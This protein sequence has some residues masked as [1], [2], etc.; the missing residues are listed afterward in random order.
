MVRAG[1]LRHRVDIE[2]MTTDTDAW[3]Q[4]TNV[5]EAVIQNL[6]AEVRDIRGREFWESQ[7]APGGEVT[8]RVRIRYRED[9]NRQMRIQHLGRV[10][11]I[12]AIVDPD[13]RMRELHLM[14][15]EAS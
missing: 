1:I 13:G 15:A 3:G 9:L 6:P 7:Q 11:Q 2:S 14:C 12:E 10:L 4:P 5:W 8:T